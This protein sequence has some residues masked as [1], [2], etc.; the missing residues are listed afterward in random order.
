[1]QAIISGRCR[2]AL[3]REGDDFLCVSADG[4]EQPVSLSFVADFLARAVDAEDLAAP[5][6]RRVVEVL[7]QAI[8]G[9]NALLLALVSMD[10]TLGAGARAS[11]VSA[12]E[13]LIADSAVV[14]RVENYLY[15]RPLPPCADIDGAVSLCVDT[16]APAL[17]A[18]MRRLIASQPTIAHVVDALGAIPQDVLSA[19]QRLSLE[20]RALQYGWFR[21]F[22]ARQMA[23]EGLDGALFEALAECNSARVGLMEWT[24]GL[25]QPSVSLR[26]ALA[27]EEGDDDRNPPQ[28]KSRQHLDR[29][30]TFESA[31]RQ[32]EAT[33]QALRQGN[34]ATATKYLDELVSYNMGRGGP[35]Y[36]VK[37]LC[38]VASEAGDIGFPLF[39]RAA[40]E[41]ATELLPYD[42]WSWSQL[43]HFR[44]M[45]GDLPGAELAYDRAA[46]YGQALIAARGRADLLV[47]RRHL[48]EALDA[49]DEILKTH[50]EDVVARNG[51]AEVLKALYRLPEALDAYDEILKAHPENVVARTGRAE[52]LCLLGRQGEALII[53]DE[54]LGRLTIPRAVAGVARILAVEGRPE[55]A[56]ATLRAA[57]AAL[58]SDGTLGLARGMI[59]VANGRNV[60]AEQMSSG[61]VL[62]GLTPIARDQHRFIVALAEYSEGRFDDASRVL[63]EF[64]TELASHEV[65]LLL[66]RMD[67]LER[68]GG[69][70]DQ[71]RDLDARIPDDPGP[72]FSDVRREVVSRFVASDRSRSSHDSV[73]QAIAHGALL[74]A[75]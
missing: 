56:L 16:D 74:S 18:M 41:R 67:L 33:T 17:L 52:V 12:A 60:E 28:L 11:A 50:P 27:D 57:P 13:S 64:E 22:V 54:V 65:D 71:I 55:E 58:D 63:A 6:S 48:P 36:A 73:C 53:Y 72:L 3:I 19:D 47:R 44:A 25:A 23:G 66:L 45:T 32:V 42:G 14:N 9:E 2:L 62:T 8:A 40:C 7:V 1:M 21:V 29:H 31:R 70:A 20:A 30:A 46:E 75:A 24:R 4:A 61:L 39:A 10:A 5:D 34:I 43:G 38:S 35:E 51:R 26:P 49:Y 59:L 37:S 69:Q 15:A 68:C